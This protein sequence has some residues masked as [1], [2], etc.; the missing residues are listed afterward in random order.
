[1]TKKHVNQKCD[2]WQVPYAEPPPHWDRHVRI[3]RLREGGKSFVEIARQWTLSKSAA[4]NSH[5]VVVRHLEKVAETGGVITPVAPLSRCPGIT[6]RLVLALERNGIHTL[7]DAASYSEREWTRMLWLGELGISELRRLGNAS[8]QPG[9]C[10]RVETLDLVHL[11][12]DATI[13]LK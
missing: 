3:Y 1:M 6:T 2:L 11:E 13:G 10:E 4:R 12:R 5:E 8:L 9:T 7:R